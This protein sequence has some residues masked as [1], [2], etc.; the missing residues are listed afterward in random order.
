[1][2]RN[3]LFKRPDWFKHEGSWRL[4]QVFK[5]GPAVFLLMCSAFFIVGVIMRLQEG[6][7]STHAS[8]LVIAFFAGAIAYVIAFHWLT[9][10]IVWITEGFKQGGKS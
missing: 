4:A 10:L 1:M 3:F 9:R 7:D 5:L 6:R 2:L 8:L